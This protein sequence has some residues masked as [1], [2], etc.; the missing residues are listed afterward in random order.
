MPKVA[1]I[2]TK[3]CSDYESSCK[4]IIPQEWEDV[5]EEDLVEL[6]RVGGCIDDPNGYCYYLV[7]Q[8][9]LEEFRLTAK[10]IL[11]RNRIVR[12]NYEKQQ[13]K[14]KAKQEKANASRKKNLEAKE[15]QKLEELKRKYNEY[16]V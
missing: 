4:F 2:K 15:R 11:E 8:V 12:E 3:Y 14:A 6:R 16:D 5:T 9:S 7:E 1:F 10:D 13:A